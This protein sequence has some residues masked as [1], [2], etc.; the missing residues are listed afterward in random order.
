[1]RCF[2][3]G[4]I[5]NR[6]DLDELNGGASWLNGAGV[7]QKIARR[8]KASPSELNRS[9]S[10]LNQNPSTSNETQETLTNV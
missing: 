8:L 5:A 2:F 7:S 9:L 1:M 10:K 3:V 6:G 4:K